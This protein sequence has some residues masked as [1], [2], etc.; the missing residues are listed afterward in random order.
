MIRKSSLFLALLLLLVS[1]PVS[2]EGFEGMIEKAE[3]YA[4]EEDYPKALASYELA[5]KLDPE[6]ESACLGQA[7]I[8]LRTGDFEKAAAAIDEALSINPVSPEAWK[9]KCLTDALSG[10]MAALEEDSIFAAVC[11][12]DISSAPASIACLCAEEGFYA[13]AAEFFAQE[14][15][16]ALTSRQRRLYKKALIESGQ[17]ALAETLGLTAAAAQN[18]QLNAAFEQGAL[19]LVPVETEALTTDDFD[20]PDELWTALE[21][22]G[23]QKPDDLTAALEA[24][25]EDSVITLYS[26]SPAG[27]SGLLQIDET[28]WLALYGGKYRLVYPQTNRGA[29]DETGDLSKFLSTPLKNLLSDGGVAYSPDGQYAAIYSTR[30]SVMMASPIMDPIII[31]LSTGEAFLAGTY[32][33]KPT[34]DNYGVMTTCCFSADGQYFYYMLWTN[35]SDCKIALHRYDLTTGETE[36]CFSG[37]DDT[38]YP[39]L[40]ETQ[41]GELFI[42][43][44]VRGYDETPGIVVMSEENGQWNAREYDHEVTA[45]LWRPRNLLYSS[46]SGYALLTGQSILGNS[47]MTLQLL[48]PEEDFAGLGRYIAISKE[49]ASPVLLTDEDLAD[50]A[51]SLSPEASS[52]LDSP[53][54]VILSTSLS[55]DGN[56]ALLITHA[57]PESS[58]NLYL[59]RLSD[60]TLKEVQLPEDTPL[61][62]VNMLYIDWNTDTIL[63]GTMNGPMAFRFE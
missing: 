38:Y 39:Q 19:S 15:I 18:E 17:E 10:D 5:R 41:E 33:N 51:E 6:N 35:S 57:P 4:A 29:S 7:D 43:R 14:D 54:Q 26:L 56:Y 20:F 12:L 24:E 58:P 50:C 62:L 31:D 48:R 8:H 61:P 28:N 44:E 13:R 37:Y 2:A 63:I 49:E 52:V 34:E 46:A 21:A 1:F 47:Y 22:N 55:P 9:L 23:G 32:S 36:F 27:N 16:G 25:L 59:M 60:L 42:L 3:A 30:Y 53:Y 45:D 40:A 11:G